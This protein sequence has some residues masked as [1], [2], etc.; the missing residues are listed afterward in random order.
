MLAY[1]IFG[2]L[3]QQNSVARCRREVSF[4]T[5]PDLLRDKSCFAIFNNLTHQTSEDETELF[6]TVCGQDCTNEFFSFLKELHQCDNTT[7]LK[8]DVIASSLKHPAQVLVYMLKNFL[9]VWYVIWILQT[10]LLDEK[11][12]KRCAQRLRPVLTD[13][14]AQC[15]KVDKCHTGFLSIWYKDYPKLKSAIEYDELCKTCPDEFG[16][17]DF[18]KANWRMLFHQLIRE[19]NWME[20]TH[21]SNSEIS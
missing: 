17:A 5:L 12:G 6:N 1:G 2:D 15:K 4:K 20:V 16:K 9:N 14:P 7:S 8:N 19:W 10:C 18:C 21:Y 13:L 11:S 3:S